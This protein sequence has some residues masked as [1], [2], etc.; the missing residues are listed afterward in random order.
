MGYGKRLHIDHIRLLLTYQDT[1]LFRELDVADTLAAVLH[2]H[3][4]YP[5]LHHLDQRNNNHP[6]SLHDVYTIVDFPE[7]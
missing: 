6:L 4:T 7:M 3:P 1:Q 5:A 2:Q